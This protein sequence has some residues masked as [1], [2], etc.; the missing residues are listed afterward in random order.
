MLE[1]A[2]LNSRCKFKLG[3]VFWVETPYNVVVGYKRFGGS[4]CPQKNFEFSPPWKRQISHFASV[5]L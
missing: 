3:W 1:M 2:V 5:R 4:C